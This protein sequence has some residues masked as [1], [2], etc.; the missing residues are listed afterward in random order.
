MEGLLV[1][2]KGT[3][4]YKD[5]ADAAEEAFKSAAYAAAAAKAAVELSRSE[6]HNP[7]DHNCSGLVTEENN[8]M[9]FKIQNTEENKLRRTKDQ[10]N[11]IG[12]GKVDPI[13]NYHSESEDEIN[14]DEKD[15]ETK[16][17]RTVAHS[18]PLEGIVC[19]ASDDEMRNE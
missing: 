10:N 1:S 8:L 9:K 18:R 16:E 17:G 3:R 19:Y 14:V 12:F 2:L 6:S 15:E 13:Q 4:K 11:V 7:A 5:V